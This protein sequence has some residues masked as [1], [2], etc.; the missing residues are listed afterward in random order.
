MNGVTTGKRVGTLLAGGLLG[1]GLVWSGCGSP[2]Q[3]P[4]PLE[5][6][7]DPVVAPGP[8][9][10]DERA[11]V[12]EVTTTRPKLILEAP[13]TAP[14]PRPDASAGE[15]DRELARGAEDE[16][17]FRAVRQE[18]LAGRATPEKR[19]APLEAPATVDLDGEGFLA[20]EAPAAHDAA[21]GGKR[22]QLRPPA[23]SPPPV[24]DRR[25]AGEEM[26]L[27]LPEPPHRP[28]PMP[29]PVPPSAR[30]VNDAPYRD[31][32]FQHYGVNPTI[33]V[34]EEPVSTFSID[35]D[36]ASYSV[37][38]SYLERGH[39]PPE[40]AV[41]IEEF[42]NSFDYRYTAPDEGVFTLQAEAFPSPNRAGYH[43]LHLGLK[44]REVAAAHRKPANLV[45]VVD[46]SG[47]MAQG[48]RMALVQDAL[49]ML[50]GSLR[51]GDT[52]G[53][54]SYATEGHAVL[55]PVGVEARDRILRAIDSLRPAGS[56]NAQAGLELG[57]RMAARHLRP[58]AVNRVILCSDGVAN[59][60][61][62]TSAGGI[63]DSVRSEAERGITLT[64][65]GVGMGNFNDVLLEQLADR[66]NGHYAYVDDRDEARRIF[67]EELAGTLEVIAKDV[68]I[69]VEFDPA[70]VSRYRLLGYENRG[71]AAR[72]FDDDRI[73]A[74]EIGAGH[75]VTALYEVKLVEPSETPDVGT[76]RIRYKDPHGTRSSKIEKQLPR[77]IVR[78]TWDDAS[79]PTRL[80]AVVA[81]FAEKLRGS[82]WVRN[83][84]WADLD[85]QLAA[86]AP[87]LEGRTEVRELAELVDRARQLDRRGD[88][89]ADE[90]PLAMMT[91]DHVPI[92]R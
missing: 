70:S 13:P 29:K 63:L 82:Y 45:F 19:N 33:D 48:N 20:F 34:A 28:A 66:G 31:M 4:E 54:V 86:L 47:S 23:T 67:A 84:A 36:T 64:A 38:R 11:D 57:Y 12:P 39:L 85:R 79:T 3:R 42:V 46:R 77:S 81:T 88:P 26:A 78:S 30:I 17:S 61:R 24:R 41:R 91:F 55:E 22:T 92:I 58:G 51:P 7:A 1:A 2:A 59:T 32:Y 80:S 68:K 62:T 6:P 87:R 90:V 37:A 5:Q 16:E 73:D 35:V 9:R 27:L 25:L 71:L 76:V 44:G 53:I 15:R 83:V 21:P 10:L 8:V 40:A 43:V 18:R 69:Q 14:A 52:V 75:T 89:F 50:V 72:D 65:V 60:G 49:R 56:T 74:G